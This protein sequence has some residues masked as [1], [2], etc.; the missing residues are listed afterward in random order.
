MTPLRLDGHYGR[1]VTVDLCEACSGL[2]FDGLEL[3]QLTPGATLTVLAR[4]GARSEGARPPL[5]EV[6]PCPRCGVRL[7]R[8]MDRS[9]DTRFETFRC[10]RAHGRFMTFSAFLRARQFVRDLS[11]AEV[12]T[13]PA[14]VRQTRCIGCGAA[15]DLAT[16]SA[17][18]YCRA[19]IAVVD[20]AQLRRTVEELQ[21][22][23]AARRMIDPTW[24]L[25]AAR[26]ARQTEAAF[27]T[28]RSHG[29]DETSF[30]LVE[31]GL[32]AL[33]SIVDVL[34]GRPA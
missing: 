7:A 16:H 9:H 6:L 11:P 10:R 18:P 24:P 25:E 3:L 12:A 20:P 13:L 29:Q 2:W 8:A 19:A 23:E 4:A 27:A 31:D 1:T 34:S 26:V 32:T 22:A 33:W 15:V 28:L 21:A 14:E 17:C 5:A 30:A